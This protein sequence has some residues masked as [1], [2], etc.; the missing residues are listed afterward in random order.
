MAAS[1]DSTKWLFNRVA[2]LKRRHFPFGILQRYFH[3]L[4]TKTFKTVS[5]LQKSKMATKYASFAQ[6]S[7]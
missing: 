4:R 1:K 2:Q 6:Q 5:R 3:I 7:V